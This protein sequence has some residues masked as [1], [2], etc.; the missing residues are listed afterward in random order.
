M[1]N[2]K[3]FSLLP[4]LLLGVM[5]AAPRVVA[6]QPPPAWDGASLQPLGVVAVDGFDLTEKPSPAPLAESSPPAQARQA[7][8]GV[9]GVTKSVSPSSAQVGQTVTYTLRIQNA[10]DITTTFYLTDVL[11]AGLT[12]VPG[13]L[14][15]PATYDT[16][17]NAIQV[18]T[19]LRPPM[20]Y[21]FR[22]AANPIPFVDVR[23]ISGTLSVCSQF[24]SC[25]DSGLNIKFQSAVFRLYDTVTSTLAAVS[26]GFVKVGAVANNDVTTGLP[27]MPNPARPNNVIALFATDLDLNGTLA[28]DPGYGDIYANT[29]TNHPSF[30]GQTVAVIQ[31]QD[32]VPFTEN[33]V[34]PPANLPKYTFEL[35]AVSGTD[36]YYIV[37][38]NTTSLYTPTLVIGVENEYGT[39]GSSY[40][41]RNGAV[42]EGTFP[43]STPQSN[44]TLEMYSFLV[45]DANT[46]EVT[47]MALPN[48][49]GTIV[50]T[51]NYTTN[52]SAAPMQASAEL[53]VYK[54]F[55][56]PLVAK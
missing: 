24:S 37:Y 17:T 3:L 42:E 46:V 47:F 27:K 50:N 10:D 52:Q 51:A 21:A 9:T 43:F 32:A 12:Y 11:P 8:A 29:L 15:G 14:K 23:G 39:V 30:P 40:Y 35:I 4:A 45:Q 26:N 55:Y 53:W 20:N 16:A 28:S 2:K 33:P 48:Q 41:F 5:A 19:T 54:K 36:Q 49:I 7:A 31:Y 22:V 38:S 13:T 25:D 56:L 44:L 18:S 34:M 6:Q 1:K